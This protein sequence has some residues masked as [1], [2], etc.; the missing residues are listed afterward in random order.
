MSAVRIRAA[1]A[2]DA[3][4]VAR[5]LAGWVAETD[6]LP[7]VHPAGSELEFARDLIG[8]GWVRVAEAGGEFAGFIARD[9]AEIQAL[10]VARPARGRGVGA[11]LLCEAQVAQ[12]PLN[13]WVFQQNFA[14]RRFYVRH[15]FHEV[16]RTDGAGNDE[17]L[18]DIRLQWR[19]QTEA[20]A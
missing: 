3:P 9:G 2:E 6:W 16:G 17:K 5:V 10:Y 13:L 4:E 18:P 12:D 7:R 11:R 1:R 20:V 14:A 15:G 8:R 19:A